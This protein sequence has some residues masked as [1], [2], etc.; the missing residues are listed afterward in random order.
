MS[1]YLY[2]IIETYLAIG[3]S[4]KHSIRARPLLGQNIPTNMKVECSSKMRKSH[5]V[6]TKFKI[7]AKIKDNEELQPCLYTSY[8]WSYEVVSDAKANQ[9]IRENYINL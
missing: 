7:K 3:E 5:P 2:V 6:G 4:S 9:F 1:D 8:K